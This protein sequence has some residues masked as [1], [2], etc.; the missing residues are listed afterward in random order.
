MQAMNKIQSIPIWVAILFLIFSVII[1]YYSHPPAQVTESTATSM[2]S[3]TVISD[4]E[5]YR[6]L[7][8]LSEGSTTTVSAKSK[9][10]TLNTL[11]KQK[12]SNTVTDSDKLKLL[13]SLK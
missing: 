13:E 2:Q 8:Q 4:A 6:I 9:L 11:Q 7:D 5:K 1:I 10:Q 3:N 12:S